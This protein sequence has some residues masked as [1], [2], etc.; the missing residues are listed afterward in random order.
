MKCVIKGLHCERLDLK[1]LTLLKLLNSADMS[2]TEATINILPVLTLLERSH[3]TSSL[4]RTIYLYI[5]P[6]L[7]EYSC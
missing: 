1:S 3:K 6:F 7:H 4:H 5:N 2:I